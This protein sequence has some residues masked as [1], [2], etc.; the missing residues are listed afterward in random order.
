[1]LTKKSGAG[2]EGRTRDIQLGRLTLCQLSYSRSFARRQI[3]VGEGFEPSKAEPADL[4]SAPVDR[5]G[6]PP[7]KIS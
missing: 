1:M 3:V 7:D 5:L 4:Q 6:T 2:D